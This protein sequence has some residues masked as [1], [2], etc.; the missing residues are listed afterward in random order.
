MKLFISK[1]ASSARPARKSLR[2]RLTAAALVVGT[3]LGLL[4][5]TGTASADNPS[6]S[7]FCGR[8]IVEQA[9]GTWQE[10]FNSEADQFY[11]L[12]I[13]GIAEKLHQGQWV[14]VP[15][16]WAIEAA[17]Q[18]MAGRGAQVLL[19]VKIPGF[20]KLVK[21]AYDLATQQSGTLPAVGAHYLHAPVSF[22][23][24]RLRTAPIHGTPIGLVNHGDSVWIL[25]QSRASDGTLWDYVAMTPGGRPSGW[26][27][28]RLVYTG[29][30]DQVTTS[31]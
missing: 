13:R 19:S 8:G 6:A 24:V 5:G 29:T 16:H 17:V 14:C 9:T 11:D 7:T 25:C 27:A 4:V 15:A 20:N 23:S 31:C 30:D 18:S 22:N 12:H 28:D 1:A 10:Q 26:V 3:C 21:L 2:A